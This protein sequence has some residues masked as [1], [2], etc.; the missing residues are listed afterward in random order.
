[1]AWYDI[2]FE[3]CFVVIV[4]LFLGGLVIPPAFSV[5]PLLG[6]ILL[7]IALFLLWLCF[8]GN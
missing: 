4:V 5:H 3:G 1:M 7:A 6:L 8:Q 2:D